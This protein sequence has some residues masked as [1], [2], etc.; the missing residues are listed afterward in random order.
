MTTRYDYKNQAWIVDDRYIPCGHPLDM[1]CHYYGRAHAGEPA[2][3]DE[4]EQ[5]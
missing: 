5:Q 2:D 3:A 4:S 1:D